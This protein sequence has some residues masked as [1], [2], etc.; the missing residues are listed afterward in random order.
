[1]TTTPEAALGKP[2]FSLV[3]HHGTRVTDKTYRGR[4]TLVFFGFTN[5]KV[6]CPRALQKL[7]AVLDE[8]GDLADELRPLYI[9]VDPDRDTPE[10]LREFLRPHPRFTGLTGST[11]AIEHAKREFRVFARRKADPDDPD[12][13]S[14]PH[15][16]ITY[17]ISPEGQYAAHFPDALTVTEITT[18][19]RD[20]LA[21]QCH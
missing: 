10:A 1:M 6:V 19:V 16:A 7:S 14:V 11:E 12:G 20:S 3:D 15:T 18:G 17:L 8:L 4:W 9:T 5:C 2:S 13:Y 21:P